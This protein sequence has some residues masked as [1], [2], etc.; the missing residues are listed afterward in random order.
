M[1]RE[2]ENNGKGIF[3]ENSSKLV[4][5]FNL[6]AKNTVMQ[7]SFNTIVYLM[8]TKGSEM[9]EIFKITENWRKKYLI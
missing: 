8:I 9:E 4:F 7:N 5:S 1:I 6:Q 3:G 2:T